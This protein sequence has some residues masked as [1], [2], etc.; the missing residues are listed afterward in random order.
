[1][2]EIEWTLFLFWIKLLFVSSIE[3][4]FPFD[5]LL[6]FAKLRYDLKRLNK[7]AI[8]S[9]RKRVT[10]KHFTGFDNVY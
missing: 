5:Y 6:L 7:C 10:H 2:H 8:I 3:V 4:L 9:D 1:M